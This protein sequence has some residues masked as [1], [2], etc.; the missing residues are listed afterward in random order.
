MVVQFQSLEIL[1]M[2]LSLRSSG[3]TGYAAQVAIPRKSI[4]PQSY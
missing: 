4:T 1:Y 2:L 3:T